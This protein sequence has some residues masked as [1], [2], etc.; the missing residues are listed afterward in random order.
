MCQ[1]VGDGTTTRAR[2][3]AGAHELR[4]VSSGEPLRRRR[5]PLS[6]RCADQAPGPM[7]LSRRLWSAPKHATA[8][9]RC[10]SR[11]SSRRLWSARK[12]ATARACAYG[13]RTPL[14]G[15]V[16]WGAGDARRPRSLAPGGAPARGSTSVT[17]A[18]Q[19]RGRPVR[20]ELRAWV[21]SEKDVPPAAGAIGT[22]RSA[23]AQV[24]VAME[25]SPL[26]AGSW[27]PL[28]AS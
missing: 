24:S 19:D 2:W 11:V 9:R 17:G 22:G 25:K 13:C 27:S 7:C 20:G 3:R 6:A 23:R 12:Y 14:L 18:R 21:R 26:V 4:G 16:V 10:R 1:E 15:R 5:V 28:V 8:G